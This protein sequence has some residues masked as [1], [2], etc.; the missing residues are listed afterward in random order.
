MRSHA[1]LKVNRIRCPAAGGRWTEP[2]LVGSRHDAYIVAREE[3]MRSFVGLWIL[4]FALVANASGGGSGAG[5]VGASATAA[6]GYEIVELVRGSWLRGANGTYV[7]PDGHLYVASVLSGEIV[8]FDVDSGDVVHRFGPADGVLN[9]DD[10]T[11]GPDGSLYWTD[12]FAG[13]VG[14]RAPDGTVTKQAVGPGVNPIT[15]SA[16]GRLFVSRCFF[17]DG[18]YELDPELTLPPRTIVE[19]DEQNPLPLGWLNAFDFGPDG[20]LVGPLQAKGMFISIDVDSC[21][22]DVGPLVGLRR[23]PPGL[24]VPHAHGGEVRRPRRPSTSSIC[25]RGR[26][27]PSTSRPANRPWWP[28]PGKAST[29]WRSTRRVG[30]S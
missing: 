27:P 3:L 2:P 21:E 10:L 7:G 1:N 9:P 24:G 28:S 13:E 11:F 18:L 15:F 12:L 30:C 4:S 19:A 17:G 26:C 16:D 5:E 14:R 23:A 6:P 8:A 25:G 22:G 29:T 20:R